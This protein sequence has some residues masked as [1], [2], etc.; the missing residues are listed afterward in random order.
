MSH[1]VS[2]LPEDLAK[3]F[4]LWL[5]L[6]ASLEKGQTA[7]LAGDVTELEKQTANQLRIY[8]ELRPL[9]EFPTSFGRIKVLA[10]SP[11]AVAENSPS[12]TPT[13]PGAVQDEE[14][15]RRRLIQP[16]ERVRHLARLHAALLRA[17][18]RSVWTVAH[19]LARENPTYS[20]HDPEQLRS[21]EARE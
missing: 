11:D 16:Q 20:F 17:V 14:D 10:R 5:E 21:L 13:L 4:S 7:L 6:A 2:G 8:S 12:Q 1:H 19:L 18:S 15:V 3:R 9:A